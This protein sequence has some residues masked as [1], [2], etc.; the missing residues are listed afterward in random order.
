MRRYGLAAL[1]L[2]LAGAVAGVFPGCAEMP[3]LAEDARMKAPRLAGS[4]YTILEEEGMPEML[5]F[6]SDYPCVSGIRSAGRVERHGRRATSHMIDL[7]LVRKNPKDEYTLLLD[8]YA[9]ANFHFPAPAANAPVTIGFLG[10]GRDRAAALE[11][12]AD[13][14]ASWRP[15]ATVVTGNAFPLD[16]QLKS[17]D[18]FFFKP[19]RKLT[20]NTPLIFLPEDRAV[21]PT[22]AAAALRRPFWGRDLG[23]VRLLFLSLDALK[24]PSTRAEALDWLRGN[25]R[26]NP[27]PWRVLCLSEPVFGAQRVHAKVVETF[28]TLLENGGVDLV[29]SGGANYYLRT[30]PI[31]SGHS[32]PVRYVVLGGLDADAKP[33]LGREYKA[34]L[35]TEPHVGMLTATPERLEWRAYAL[36]A[37]SHRLPLDTLAVFASERA[38]DVAGGEPLIE[39]N[40]ILTDALASLALQREVVAIVRQAA[41]AVPD[42][43]ANRQTYAFVLNNTTSQEIKGRLT[44]EQ[45]AE[46]A[47][48]VHPRAM[49]FQLQPGFSGT[50][51]F[52]MERYINVDSAPMPELTASIDGVGAASQPMLIA[53][54]KERELYHRLEGGSPVSIDGEMVEADWEKAATFADFIVLGGGAPRQN[55]EARAFYDSRG[56]YFLVRAAAY[57]PAAIPCAATA[58]DDPVHRDES[59]E[60]FFDP[61]G[62]GR[63]F[64]QFAVNLQ[65]VTLDRSSQLGLS[66]NPH[67]EAKVSLHEDYYVVE[68]FIPFAALGLVDPPKPGSRWGFDMFRNDYSLGGGRKTMVKGAA[69]DAAADKVSSGNIEE[70]ALRDLGRAVVEDAVGKKPEGD[71]PRLEVVQW[72]DTFG[73]NARS[74]CYGDLVFRAAAAPAPASASGGDGGK[75]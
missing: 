68:A 37:A 74:G 73:S 43:R 55:L 58:H 24:T 11:T 15:D 54:K 75:K 4:S 63:D 40:D 60:F 48:K 6:R 31:K 27:R 69:K 18:Q 12:A 70:Q 28:G 25:L 17:W 62:A 30:L 34:A 33:T 67:W 47:W 71:A 26:D 1:F 14:C 9:A 57:H 42:A 3:E 52:V 7:G 44:W 51:K 8:D 5:Y 22:D 41:K 35:F 72:A 29:V 13:L 56:V 66:W 16:K 2:A 46:T 19:L 39:K 50:A 36:S 23:C 20:L 65:G 53:Q 10:G 64:Y 38:E 32:K 45:A 61:A 49:E 21:M 59:I